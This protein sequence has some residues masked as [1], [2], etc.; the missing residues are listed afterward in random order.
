MIRA[1]R[2][3]RPDTAC[4]SADVLTPVERAAERDLARLPKDWTKPKELTYRDRDRK[5]GDIPEIREILLK[6]KG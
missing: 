5:W 3:P 1:R 2:E 6:V 4:M